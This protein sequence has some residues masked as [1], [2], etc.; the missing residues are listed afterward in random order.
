MSIHPNDSNSDA[1]AKPAGPYRPSL[2][3]ACMC[4]TFCVYC[5]CRLTDFTWRAVGG[6]A[7]CTCCA[8]RDELGCTHAVAALR[9]QDVAG[10][11]VEAG[12]IFWLAPLDK[13]FWLSSLSTIV[14]FR[15]RTI[16]ADPM[17]PASGLADTR[18]IDLD[19]NRNEDPDFVP[20]KTVLHPMPPGTAACRPG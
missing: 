2:P 10:L 9:K 15:H 18:F 7:F 20:T 4:P 14:R 3:P 16:D 19:L 8:K 6:L 13:Q 17:R 5:G 1:R 12:G 11:L